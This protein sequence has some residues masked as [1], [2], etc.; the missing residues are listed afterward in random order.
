MNSAILNAM[1][2]AALVLIILFAL[3]ILLRGHNAPG[4]GFIGALITCAGFVLH[5]FSFGV[6]KT[7]ALLRVNPITLMKV[8]LLCGVGAGFVAVLSGLP[9]LTGIWLPAY[10]EGETALPISSV[11]LFDVGVYLTV[12]GA[13]MTILLA[14]EEDV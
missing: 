14:L 1:T 12:I 11:L 5:Q 3:Y 10:L 6:E 2:R 7:R 4:G 8:G 13:I 9:F